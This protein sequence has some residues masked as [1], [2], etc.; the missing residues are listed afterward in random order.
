MA[1]LRIGIDFGLTNTDVVLVHKGKLLQHWVLPHAGPAS[2]ALVHK[3]L[4]AGK[5]EISE[6]EAIATTGGLH[7]TLP[8]E[9]EG[10]PLYKAGEAEAVGRGGLALAGL[11]E[12]LVVSAGTGTAMIAAWG[13]KT[14]HLTGSAV[15][16]GT[17]LGLAKLLIG[18]S[19]PLE[20]AHLAARGDPAGVD[21][22]LQDAIGGGIGHLPPSATAVNFGKVG[23][24]PGPPKREDIAAGLVV[25]VG[26]VIGVVALGAAKA[27]GLREVVVVGHLPDLE[28][29][30]KAILAVWEF[31]QVE[32][33]PLIP[34]E[35]GA[36]TAL[37]AVLVTADRG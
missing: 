6:L 22:T 37:G 33:K 8:D 36:A 5:Q 13:K 3:A 28:P 21:S 11:E 12:A 2:E 23:S 34:Q 4:A 10:V 29:I 19:H 16:G 26:Q 24:L 18:T 31:Y 35:A 27:A 9:I 14:Q 7:R 20:I 32:P 15:G 17:L 1:G 30:R 25:M